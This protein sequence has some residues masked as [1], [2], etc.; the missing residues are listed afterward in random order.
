MN[1]ENIYKQFIVDRRIKEKTL[2]GYSEKHHILPRSLGGDDSSENLI[3]LS[4]GDHF[5]A[6]LLLAKT[7]GGKMWQALFLMTHEK[8]TSAK[9]FGVKRKWYEEAKKQASK[10]KS[11]FYTGVKQ[12]QHREIFTVY[13]VD[14]LVVTGAQV[15]I[16]EKTGLSIASVSRLANKLQGATYS[17]WYMFEDL[18]ITSKL[19]KSTSAYKLGSKTGGWNKKK[20]KCLETGKIF[21]DANEAA[22]SLGMSCGK[23]IRSVCNGVRNVAGGYR[24]VYA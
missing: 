3:W 20:V 4:S 2:T 13:N 14:G 9:G 5:F 23:N 21:S 1:Y 18:M 7:Y 17:G 16:C 15:D 19:S 22:K 10:L 8:T 12:R 11:E 24:W 6:H